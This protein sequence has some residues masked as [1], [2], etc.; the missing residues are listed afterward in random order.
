MK[1]TYYLSVDKPYS[2]SVLT[3]TDI[4]IRLP[5]VGD[6]FCMKSG[7]NISFIVIEVCHFFNGDVDIY[8]EFENPI[9]I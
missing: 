5:S 2:V 7:D 4:P 9:R 3:E 6:A 8:L 1:T